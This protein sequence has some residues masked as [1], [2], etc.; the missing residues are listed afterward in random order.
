MTELYLP[1]KLF[2]NIEF[3]TSPDSQTVNIPLRVKGSVGFLVAFKKKEDAE[4][5]GVPVITITVQEDTISP[6]MGA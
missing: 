6:T 5:F 4:S 2:Q 1:S 3:K